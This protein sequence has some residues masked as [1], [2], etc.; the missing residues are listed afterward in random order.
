MEKVNSG[1]ALA[2]LDLDRRLKDETSYQ[3]KLRK[4]Q[5]AMLELE[6]ILS[7]ASSDG[8]A[9]SRSRAGM[10]QQERRN[11]ATD[12]KAR[13]TLGAGL[14]DRPAQPREARPPL[15]LAL[16]AEVAASRQYHDLRLN[17]VRASVLVEPVDG[18]AR[19]KE[20]RRAYDEVNAFEKML[21]D[22]GVRLVKLFLHMSDGEQLRR[23]RERVI[24]PT[25]HWKMTAEDI[26]NRA[27]RRDYLAALDDMFARWLRRGMSFRRNINGTQASP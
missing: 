21:I 16:L 25:K 5:I 1:F 9:S 6:E 19:P 20:W 23:F 3:Q 8:A 14:V 4:L 10:L 11:P 22:D 2:E 18:L 24:T 27:R 15:S 26:H 7:I 12:R 13:P 17:L